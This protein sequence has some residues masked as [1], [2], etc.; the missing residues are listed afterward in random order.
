M[1]V[2]LVYPDY[3][4]R[5]DPTSG[6]EGFYSEGIACLSSML[7]S[8]G[9]EVSLLHYT[10]MPSES[11]Y[12]EAIKRLNPDLIGFS[13][14]TTIYPDV[15]RMAQ[16]SKKHL[17]SAF[18]IS[19]GVHITLSV[20]QAAVEGEALDALCVGEGEYPLA[21]L[22]EAL[23]A[24]RDH[25][26][27]PSIWARKPDRTWV[28][29]PTRPLLDNLDELPLP[30][31][32]IFDMRKLAAISIHTAPVMLSRGCPYGC[33][34]C[35]N[36]QIKEAYPNRNKYVRFRS[37]ARSIE[38]IKKVLEEYPDT[39][40]LNFMENVLPLN[41]PWFYEFIE[42][43]KKE[44][45]LPYVC[46][47]RANLVDEEILHLL[48]DSGCYL[49]HFG[50]ENGDNRI[51]DE[52][53]NRGLTREQMI[54]AFDACRR[55]GIPTLTYNMVGL[56]TETLR[57]FRETVRL[58]A[59]L[60]ASR[61]V[62]SIFCPYPSTRL[63]E[64]SRERGLLHL[65]PDFR[66]ENYLDLPGFPNV[67][68][69]FAARYFPLLVRLRRRLGYLPGPLGGVFRRLID[70]FIVTKLKPHGLLVWLMD[71]ALTLMSRGKRFLARAHPGIYLGLRNWR[72]QKGAEGAVGEDEA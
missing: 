30:D 14:R 69:R 15:C 56:P 9:H 43:Y 60:G 4:A 22:C 13:S 62:I 3:S 33:T 25:T 36:H 52:I 11:E 5:F 40:Y 28:K 50:V 67:Q 10:S 51:L 12:A 1:R 64:Y 35:C 55:I 59:R 21:E 31:F 17:P 65:P 42:L 39:K 29:N 66:T 8:R 18:T 2:L 54:T 58:N 37:P 41:K 27:I 68:V 38:Y 63:Y 24:G 57:E 16:W 53:L 23:E 34:Y 44:I 47:Y 7:K 26:N 61:T 32:A 45:G 6:D 71:S 20:E 46:R 70:W 48:K 19:G 49:I 72:V